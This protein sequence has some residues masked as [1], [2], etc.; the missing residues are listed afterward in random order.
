M[1]IPVAAVMLCLLVRPGLA[2]AQSSDTLGTRAQ[3]MGGAFVGVADDASAVYWNPAGLA[4]G[5]Y[6]SLVL[7][8]NTAQAVPDGAVEGASRTGWLLALSTPALGL[9]YARLQSTRV[10]PSSGIPENSHVESLLTQHLGATLVQSL[11]DRLAV[12]ATVKLI[13]GIAASAD[14]AG[15][16][17]EELLD[18]VDL[19]GHASNRVDLDVGV[20]AAGSFGRAGLTVRNLTAPTFDTASGDELRLQRQ[21]RGG[22]SIL[23]LPSWKLAADVDLLEIDAAFGRLREISFGTEGQVSRRLAA[24]AGVRLNSAGDAAPAVAVGASYAV[25]GSVQIDGQVTAGSNKAFRGWGIA[26][27]MVF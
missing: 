12:G 23:L 26:G 18:H 25:L 8:G 14:V 17:R 13:R 20:M 11:A 3:G 19:I 5:A 9:S 6:F 15:N 7:D 10:R 24:R 2:G 21:V 4:G 27:R 16:D 1:R 22:A